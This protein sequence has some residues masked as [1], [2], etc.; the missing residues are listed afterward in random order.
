MYKKIYFSAAILFFTSSILIAQSSRSINSN[1]F[2]NR[3]LSKPSIEISYGISN[4]RL[5]GDSYD[6]ANAGMIEVKLGFTSEI[7]SNFGENILKYKNRFLF[8]R[9]ASS[10]NYSSSG[11]PGTFN[12]L[13][14]F[15]LGNKEG[16]GVK[17]GSV[18]ILPYSSNSIAW[19]EISYPAS[20]ETVSENSALADFNNA[21]RFGTTTEAGINLQLSKGFSIQPEFEISDI[22]PRHLFGKQLMSSVIELGGLYLIDDFTKLIMSNTPVAG[23]FVNFILKNAYEYGFYQLRKNQ[24]YWPFTSVAPLRYNTFKLGMTF[25]F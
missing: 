17:P 4:I 8:L 21:F 24:M 6:L 16:Y 18:S 1:S 3:Y 19:S 13:W 25:I 10:D 14:S 11:N 12:D 22:F 5:N 15:G 23:T 2:F 9:N 20:M 7:K